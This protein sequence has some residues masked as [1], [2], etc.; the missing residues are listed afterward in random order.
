MR[1]I[2]IAI[3]TSHYPNLPE[4]DQRP[5]L[6]AVLASVVDMFTRRIGCYRHVLDEVSDNPPADALRKALD[7]WFAADERNQSD[8]VVLYYTGHAQIAGDETLYLLT[9]DFVP[10]QYVGTAFRLGRPGS[11]HWVRPW[12]NGDAANS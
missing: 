10:G 5:Q 4:S 2:L 7:R 3:A 9:S 11:A 12:F 6:S 1:H 8:W